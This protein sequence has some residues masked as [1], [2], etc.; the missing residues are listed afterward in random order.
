M[1]KMRGLPMKR[2]WENCL[3]CLLRTRSSLVASLPRNFRLMCRVSGM[4]SQECHDTRIHASH[5]RTHLF[6][7]SSP[8]NRCISLQL[9]LFTIEHRHQNR[10]FVQEITHHS[11]STPTLVR[12][13]ERRPLLLRRSCRTS[14]RFAELMTG[15]VFPKWKCRSTIRFKC[16]GGRQRWK[17]QSIR[18]LHLEPSLPSPRGLWRKCSSMGQATPKSHLQKPKPGK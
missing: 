11:T 7:C 6:L 5:R 10:L 14:L 3:T 18:P 8:K 12:P 1:R 17:A 4:V 15:L 13:Q 2:S 16:W 9:A